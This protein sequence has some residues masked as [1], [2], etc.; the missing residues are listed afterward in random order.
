MVMQELHWMATREDSGKMLSCTVTTERPA[1]TIS[2]DRLLHVRGTTTTPTRTTT[3][4]TTHATNR[5]LV[6][7][8][9][10]APCINWF[11]YYYYYYY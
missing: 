2:S 4:T 9:F 1:F 3:T 10:L 6:T 8:C 7:F 5:R 11:Y